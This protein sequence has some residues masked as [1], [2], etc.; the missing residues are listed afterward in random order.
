MEEAESDHWRAVY[1]LVRQLWPAQ[2]ALE[3]A[4]ADTSTD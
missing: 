1:G 2:E 3:E 4:L